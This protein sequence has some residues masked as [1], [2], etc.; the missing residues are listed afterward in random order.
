MSKPSLGFLKREPQPNKPSRTGVR[1]KLI[2]WAIPAGIAIGIL[3]LLAA[4]F[5]EQLLPARSVQLE[6]VA[7]LTASEH[8]PDSEQRTPQ[9]SELSFDGPVLFQAS[10]WIEAY[11]Q[12]V[13]ATALISGV[14]D[15]VFVLE[16]ERVEKGD[17]IATLIDED[18]RLD[19]QT[20]KAAVD[21]AQ[22]RLAANQDSQRSLAARQ[23]SLRHELN[24][25]KAQLTYLEEH[26]RSRSELGDR[27][28]SELQILEARQMA[29]SQKAAVA[30]IQAKIE[31]AEAEASRLEKIF[32]QHSAELAAA[33]TE[34]ARRQLALDRTR[35]VAPISGRVSELFVVPGQQRMHGADDPHSADIAHLYDPE[36]LQARIDVPLAEAS[37]IAIGQPVYLRSNFLP[38]QKFRGQVIRIDGR[39]DLQRNTLQAKVRLLDID[40]RLRPDMLCRAEFLAASTTS[41]SPTG[42]AV[43]AQTRARVFIPESA[44]IDRSGEQA[45]TWVVDASGKHIEKRR[46]ELGGERRENYRLVKEGLRPGDRVVISP[47]ADLQEGQR[48]QPSSAD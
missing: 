4:L 48:V 5:G 10:G 31:E 41:D 27:S 44:L 30:A 1:H 34:L 45:H 29:E 43:A 33:E 25:A 2:T 15:N 6:T 40:D 7:T 39:A 13:K 37:A 11:P 3:I 46:L 8:S 9:T 26:A 47:A 38:D 24:A 42:S 12:A 28:V 36:Q 32:T 20:A 35:I 14:V 19:L 16:G 22:A 21:A 18:A 17:P 23:R